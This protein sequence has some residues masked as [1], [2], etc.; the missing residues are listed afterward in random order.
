[1]KQ[2]RT[3]FRAGEERATVFI[4]RM[5]SPKGNVELKGKREG[6]IDDEIYSY[7]YSYSFLLLLHEKAVMRKL[8]IKRRK[9]FEG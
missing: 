1:M 2:Q 6:N 3:F 5:I 4:S 9:K 7:S 8:W